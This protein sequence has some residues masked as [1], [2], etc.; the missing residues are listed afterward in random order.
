MIYLKI[1]IIAISVFIFSCDNIKDTP[2]VFSNKLL[3]EKVEKVNQPN[4]FI[5]IWRLIKINRP[6]NQKSFT[7]KEEIWEIS[8]KGEICIK[9]EGEI[10]DNIYCR[11]EFSKSGF[12]SDST[13]V[14]K[15]SFNTYSSVNMN[16]LEVWVENDKMELIEQCD[17]CS[18]YEFRKEE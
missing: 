18:S 13:C 7:P 3:E 17:D 16:E 10:I 1:Y 5:G 15:G 12:S 4:N 9:R 11:F 6:W 8:N 2:K 14:I